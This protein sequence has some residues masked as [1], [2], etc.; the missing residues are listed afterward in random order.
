MKSACQ[1]PSKYAQ[2][3]PVVR[4]QERRGDDLVVGV[5]RRHRARRHHA[6]LHGGA[7][8]GLLAGLDLRAQR[9][10]AEH[11]DVDV[12]IGARLNQALEM[13]HGRR[14]LVAGQILRQQMS[15]DHGVGLRHGDA[16]GRGKAQRRYGAGRQMVLSLIGALSLGCLHGRGD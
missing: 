11:L 5:E 9:P 1:S 14:D 13:R 8:L 16:R 10:G 3:T 15:D 2:A 12:A 7:G 4:E 6:R